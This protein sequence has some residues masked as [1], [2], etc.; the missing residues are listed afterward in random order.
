MH[1]KVCIVLTGAH[2]IEK[3]VTFHK[4]G[5]ATCKIDNVIQI[6]PDPPVMNYEPWYIMH[7]DTKIGEV[8]PL[9]FTEKDWYAAI[10]EAMN[11]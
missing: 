10:K 2:S 8:F 4:S 11:K 7:G 6:I 3:M 9:N 1:L 5:H